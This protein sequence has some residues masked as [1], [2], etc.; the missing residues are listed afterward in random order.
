MRNV[1][2][3]EHRLQS[4]K[5]STLQATAGASF[6]SWNSLPSARWRNEA[7]HEEFIHLE[8]MVKLAKSVPTLIDFPNDQDEYEESS[9]LCNVELTATLAQIVNVSV[10]MRSQIDFGVFSFPL[11]SSFT[12]D[13]P[14]TD[15][16]R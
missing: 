13:C 9:N 10:L 5:Y 4:Q 15:L 1:I 3:A 12:S 6:C 8:I 7:E 11:R 2:T 14:G 16:L